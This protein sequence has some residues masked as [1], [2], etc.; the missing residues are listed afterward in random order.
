MSPGALRLRRVFVSH[1]LARIT[2][3]EFGPCT[4]PDGLTQGMDRATAMIAAASAHLLQMVAL[5][6]EGKLW[7]RDGATSMTGWL[8]A[9]YGLVRGT[10]RD[11]V[12]V[13]HALRD[14]PEVSRTHASGNLSWDQ[15]KPLARF[16]T[17]E[18]D[19]YWSKRAPGLR[20]ST[21]YRE[22][23]RH[24]QVRK[25]DTE[26][27]ERMR[28]LTMWWDPE[29]P[30][31]YLEGMLSAEQEAAFQ[32]ALERR[33]EQ[34]VLADRPDSPQ[35]AR[36]ADALV[37]SWQR[38]QMTAWPP[39]PPWWSTPGPSCSPRKS[40]PKARGSRRPSPDSGCARKPCVGSPAT[41][42]SSG[43]CIPVGA[44]WGSVAGAGRFPGRSVDYFDTVTEDAGS[45]GASA[46]AGCKPTT[47]FTGETAGGRTSTTW[48]SFATHTTG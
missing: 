32:T 25:R 5:F 38:A 16:A 15:L 8:A 9:R 20:P 45:P 6:D 36:M 41:R 42:G 4:R 34:I 26:E 29:R 3:M 22:A 35:D 1:P 11:W 13:A 37:E 21:L 33:A 10:A 28:Y 44:R 2:P 31:L 47:S 19:E 27:I 23:A 30:I 48:C 24:E 18:T 40:I 14:L 46:G 12:R 39:S 7:E 43:R 17:R